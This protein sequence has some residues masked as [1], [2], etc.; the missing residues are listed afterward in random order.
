MRKR[1]GEVEKDITTKSIQFVSLFSSFVAQNALEEQQAMV[2][3][4]SPDDSILNACLQV[5]QHVPNVILLT[6]D[7]NLRNKCAFNNITATA[8]NKLKNNTD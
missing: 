5:K 3:I 6:E 1:G 2:N 7:V 8:I 4:K